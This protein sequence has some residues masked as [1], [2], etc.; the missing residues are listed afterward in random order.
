MEA[1]V[2]RILLPCK[3]GCGENITYYG[4]EGHE[5]ACKAGPC[6]C[7]DP[8]CCF[9]GNTTALSD[10]FTTHHKWPANNFIDYLWQTC[11]GIRVLRSDEGHLFLLN[12]A[13]LE[14]HALKNVWLDRIT[15]SSLSDGLP[16]DCSSCILPSVP[17]GGDPPL[18]KGLFITRKVEDDDE[19][20]WEDDDDDDDNDD[21]YE[22][23]YDD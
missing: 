5:K 23:D 7:P 4:K 19:M 22:D 18:L 3:H 1:A 9:R 20:E 15:N 11:P 10:H 14:S 12:V 17:G 8:G 6:F 2:N 21:E 16:E 13:S